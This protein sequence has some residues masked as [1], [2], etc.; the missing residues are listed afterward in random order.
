MGVASLYIDIS[1]LEIKGSFD[2][3]ASGVAEILQNIRV[4]LT[5]FQGTVPLDREFGINPS[6]LDKPINIAK[7]LLIVE[8]IEKI[9]KYEPRAQVQTVTFEHDAS[10]G[11]LLPK[12]VIAID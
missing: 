9:K 2:F 7:G 8:Y 12:V 6:I 3:S 4:I 1:R 11:I 10:Q 5:T